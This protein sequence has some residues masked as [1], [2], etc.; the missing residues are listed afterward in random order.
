MANNTIQE[1]TEK[2]TATIQHPD[3]YISEL[4]FN[5]DSSLPITQNDIVVF[6]G[7]N[8][9][10]KSQALRD[11]YALSER[12][13]TENVIVKGLHVIKDDSFE[14]V[15]YLESICKKGKEIGIDIYKGVGFSFRIDS[16]PRLR[17]EPTFHNLRNLFVNFLKTED[18]LSIC[19]PPPIINFDET[20]THP[21]HRL[22][23][24]PK[25]R[26]KVSKY[27]ERA[28]SK[29]LIPDQHYG[30]VIPM[31]IGDEISLCE[32]ETSDA[33]IGFE[34]YA[35]RLREY[36][37]LNK[38][39]DGMRSFS[40]IL[41][42]LIVEHF[43]TFLIDEP[44]S[45]L[46]PP[47]AV[48][49]GKMIAELLSDKQQ[50]FISTHSQ[51]LIKGLLAEAPERVK[52][53]RITRN[54]NR[55]SFSILDNAKIDELW[56]DPL[57]KHS[58][59]MDG[60]FYNNVVVCESDAD[61]RF[62]SIINSHLKEQAGTF[63]ESLFVHCGGKHRM[64]KVVEALK[65]L[66]IDFRVIPDIDILN[67]ENI[68]RELVNTCEGNWNTWKKDY[69]TIKSNLEN[70]INFTGTKFLREVEKIVSDS[71]DAPLS[72]DHFQKI[73]KI[74]NY[75]TKWS[76]I[77]ES[78]LEGLPRGQAYSAMQNILDQLQDF[79]I[80]IVRYGELECFIKEVGGHG[81]EWLNNVLERYPDLNNAIFDRVKEFVSSWRI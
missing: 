63:S 2:Q 18:R 45:F 23:H 3:F 29:P 39:G 51:H 36:P 6:V 5:N 38:Q 59:I 52:I 17:G 31:R 7:P 19:N 49:M 8:N 61:C 53:V 46:H 34:R 1:N 48:I 33:Q 68:I 41:L 28:F 67:D 26:E 79:K 14:V 80:F 44:E 21:I 78:G 25:Y 43:S 77:K 24:K 9:V 13:N 74:A 11:I 32:L 73:R 30:K 20:P 70:V 15:P 72:S 64:K 57:L 71:Y 54:G 27:F 12:P 66:E 40:G 22:I 37:M 69:N 56:K 16:L 81:P 35:E 50:A 10:G 42:N 4:R 65:S 47:Q 75:Q 55:N 62:Y 60:M 76:K 58:E